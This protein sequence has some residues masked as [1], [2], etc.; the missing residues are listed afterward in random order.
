MR[1]AGVG[2]RYIQGEGLIVRADSEFGHQENVVAP[3][4]LLVEVEFQ[5][6]EEEFLNAHS[7][8]RHSDFPGA[9]AEAVKSIEST[10]KTI[11]DKKSWADQLGKTKV[12]LPEFL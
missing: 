10:L 4:A 5:G 7:K 1:E 6:A 9:M 11:C 3:H 8:Y 12:T 2:Y